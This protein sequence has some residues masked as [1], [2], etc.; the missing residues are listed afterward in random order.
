MLLYPSEIPFHGV[1]YRWIRNRPKASISFG[2]RAKTKAWAWAY[3]WILLCTSSSRRSLCPRGTTSHVGLAH[4]R[5]PR[6]PYPVGIHDPWRFSLPTLCC[7]Y[8]PSPLLIPGPA[9]IHPQSLLFQF[10]SNS[11]MN[12]IFA[13]SL[14]FIA[15]LV[16]F[17]RK[18]HYK[19]CNT[20]LVKTFKSK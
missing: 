3:G 9:Q 10:F 14:H 18:L 20:V 13:L 4:F 11:K 16:W 17:I 15:L 7:P 2:S 6:Q 12:C 1:K 19:M 8:M 5:S